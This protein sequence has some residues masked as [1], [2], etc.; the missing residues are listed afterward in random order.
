MPKA[1]SRSVVEAGEI[2]LSEVDEIV[3][4]VGSG[5]ERLV[6]LLQAIQERYRWLPGAA[7]ERVCET[8]AITPARITGVSTFYSGFRHRPVGKHV[9]RVCFGTACYVRGA[10]LIAD[11]LNRY[12]GIE[13]GSDTDPE[14]LF[15]VERV[16]C[17]GCCS[18]APCLTVEDVTYG[19]LTPQSAPKAIRDFLEEHGE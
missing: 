17:L 14:R 2:N 11:A 12:L 16:A 1:N 13:E 7:L 6:E 9:V 3:R 4:R 15:T 8:T 19:H 5:Q 18:L 10:E